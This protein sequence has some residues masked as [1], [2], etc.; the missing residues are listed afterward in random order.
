ME[1]EDQGEGFDPL[2]IPDPTAVENLERSCGRGLL[3]IADSPN[4]PKWNESNPMAARYLKAWKAL[5][6]P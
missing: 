2:T 5:R 1:V 4:E 3:L 6:K